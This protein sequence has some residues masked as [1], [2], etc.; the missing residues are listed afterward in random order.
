MARKKKAAKKNP[1]RALLGW[2]TKSKKGR[3]PKKLPKKV[4][5]AQKKNQPYYNHYGSCYMY[6]MP[7]TQKVVR[8]RGIT[9]WLRNTFWPSYEPP[10]HRGTWAARWGLTRG[11]AVAVQVAQWANSQGKKPLPKATKLT[12]QVI[13]FCKDHDWQPV[14]GELLVCI[15]TY[16]MGTGIDLIVSAPGKQGGR[17]LILVEIKVGGVGYWDKP[18]AKP[19]SA[20]FASHPNCPRSHAFIQAALSRFI[21]QNSPGHKNLQRMRICPHSY[22]LRV[23]ETNRRYAAEAEPVPAWASEYGMQ[24][25]RNHFLP[26]FLRS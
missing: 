21:F 18:A 22:V 9:E 11:K 25:L 19:M 6:K 17:W 14:A 12:Q 1:R 3:P 24:E 26:Q 15:P 4:A 10:P 23:F 16:R 8:L 13:K 2:S 7:T 20:P 5:E